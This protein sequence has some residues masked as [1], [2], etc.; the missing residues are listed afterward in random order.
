MHFYVIL[1]ERPCCLEPI[2]C[3]CVFSAAYPVPRCNY[4]ALHGAALLW[5][6]RSRIDSSDASAA[7]CTESVHCSRFVSMPDW[8][9]A[10]S[11][12][13]HGDEAAARCPGRC[14]VV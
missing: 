1:V 12:A 4:V 14:T 6:A 10:L 9:R 2:I 8:T 7:P 5:A 13:T 11:M 3:I